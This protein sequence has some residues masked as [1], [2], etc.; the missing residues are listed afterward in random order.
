MAVGDIFIRKTA[1]S[2]RLLERRIIDKIAEAQT[3]IAQINPD[4]T[5]LRRGAE[6]APAQ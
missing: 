6:P 5:D 2:D 1:N 3:Q 4:L